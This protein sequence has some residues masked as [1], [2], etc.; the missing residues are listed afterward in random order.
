MAIPILSESSHPG[1]RP[2]QCRGGG[3]STRRRTA[4]RRGPIAVRE[5]S[6]CGAGKSRAVP[7][8]FG[9]LSHTRAGVR[10]PSG[11]VPSP[12]A[13]LAKG[14]GCP[15]AFRPCSI[16]AGASHSR[17]REDSRYGLRPPR[18]RRTGGVPGKP[19]NTARC[20]GSRRFVSVVIGSLFEVAPPA[21]GRFDQRPR[22]ARQS[23]AEPGRIGLSASLE[24]LTSTPPRSPRRT[25]TQL[26][27]CVERL[28]FFHSRLN[29][30]TPPTALTASAR[31]QTE[32]RN[33]LHGSV[34]PHIH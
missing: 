13:L 15:V 11:G 22:T 23:A 7:F 10:S 26:P 14:Y 33:F 9:C 30:G 28:D 24:S 25:S 3:S 1:R 17:A 4:L 29:I 20:V 19:R 27:P 6:R 31:Y 34:L 2:A 5:S 12:W 8:P 32:P 16:P 18:R 21:G